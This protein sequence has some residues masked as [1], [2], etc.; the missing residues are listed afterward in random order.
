MTQL[1][2][3]DIQGMTEAAI[4]E[5]FLGPPDTCVH[6]GFV[7]CPREI[8]SFESHLILSC[9]VWVM[10]IT[11]DFFLSTV[12]TQEPSVMHF[13]LGEDFSHFTQLRPK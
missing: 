9:I 10:W 12:P 2:D 13:S 3:R 5:V 4:K 7:R 1:G 11:P 6:L 8:E